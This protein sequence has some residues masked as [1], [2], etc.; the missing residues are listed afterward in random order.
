V[1]IS[2]KWYKFIKEKEN[3]LMNREEALLLYKKYNSTESLLRH[4]LSVEA[5]MRHFAQH[6]NEDVEYWG[7]V[8]L[9]HDIDYELYPQEHL[10]KAPEMLKEANVDEKT[11]RAVLS[12]GWKIVTDVEPVHIM[13]KVLYTIDELT[14]LVSATALMRPSK[15]LMDLNVKSVKKKFK[16]KGFSANVNREIIL[17]GVELVGLEF[18]KIIE[19]TI[20]GMRAINEELGFNSI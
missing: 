10:K 9:L 12:H 4:S 15:S 1:G 13:E 17:K 2:L 11:I 7:N 14:G 18:D 6:F 20:E 3:L 5:V 8:G 19:L 16:T